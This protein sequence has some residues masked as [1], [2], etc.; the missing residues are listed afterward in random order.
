[1]AL[2][3]AAAPQKIN[4]TAL[5]QGRSRSLAEDTRLV[6]LTNA[7]TKDQHELVVP[8]VAK[9]PPPN[10]PVAKFGEKLFKV[11]TRGSTW[12][13]EVRWVQMN[14]LSRRSPGLVAWLLSCSVASPQTKLTVLIDAVMR[15]DQMKSSSIEML[16]LM[17]DA[18]EALSRLAVQ[19]SRHL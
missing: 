6:C 5:Q 4:V 8:P 19:T 1:M 7:D 9:P 11:H 16:Q 14:S 15:H 10:N 18:S 12:L 13:G 2:R 17:T 3:N